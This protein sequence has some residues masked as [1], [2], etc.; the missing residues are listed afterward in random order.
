MFG[1]FQAYYLAVVEQG[2][3][4]DIRNQAYVHLHKLPMS[5]FKKEKTGNL[6]SR[7]INDVNVIQNSV[8]AVFLNLIS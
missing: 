1:S 6:I 7:I 3:I 2:I 8:S 4:K 5:F